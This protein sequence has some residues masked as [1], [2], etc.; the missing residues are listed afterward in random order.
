[1]SSD[2]KSAAP[3]SGVRK[4]G[5]CKWFNSKK[6]FGF[7]TPKDGSEDVFVHQTA[8][9]AEGF[10]SL[11]EQEPVE[12]E[13]AVDEQGRIKAL[14][15]TGPTS[16]FVKGAPKPRPRFNNRTRRPRGAGRG[17]SSG[18]PGAGPQP[19]PATKSAA[20]N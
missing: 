6:G 16:A 1:M 13:T 2:S 17:G 5:V 9:H 19:T 15:V 7:I 12:Y 14:N 10:R 20:S 8:I 18:S 11:A 4:Q 3:S